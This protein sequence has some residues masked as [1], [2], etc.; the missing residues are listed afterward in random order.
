MWVHHLVSPTKRGGL[1]SPTL[2]FFS[3]SKASN[4]LDSARFF[5]NSEM[6]TGISA[7]HRTRCQQCHQ[8]LFSQSP[9]AIQSASIRCHYDSQSASDRCHYDSQSS[10]IRCPSPS[11]A[12]SSLRQEGG[13]APSKTIRHRSV[14]AD[15][16]RSRVPAFSGFIPTRML[17]GRLKR[18]RKTRPAQRVQRRLGQLTG[19]SP[20]VVTTCQ[21]SSK[22]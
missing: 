7:S 16:A 19:S 3:A 2:L 13:F 18:G 15:L 22:S 21:R 5:Y 6:K 11:G 4:R 9:T 8:Q 12:R 20:T 1:A 14:R 10:S 17:R